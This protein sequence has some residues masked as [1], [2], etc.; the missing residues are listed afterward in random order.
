MVPVMNDTKWR[1]V[2]LAMH[3]LERVVRWRTRDRHS[4]YVS[5]WD[6]DWYYHFQVGGYD[7]I[8]WVEIRPCES[9][10][11]ATIVAAL[12][13]VGVPGVV[14]DETVTVFGYVDAGQLV[15]WL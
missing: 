1:E 9:E 14:A 6:T 2:R 15:H 7:W 8:E 5:H 10:Q 11:L 4:G 3:R 13:E 12:K